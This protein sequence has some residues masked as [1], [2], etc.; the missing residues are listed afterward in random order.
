MH[1][2]CPAPSALCLCE[3]GGQVGHVPTPT[4]LTSA[5][6]TCATPRGSDTCEL[7][8]ENCE[9]PCD[10]VLGSVDGG[11]AVMM[12]GLDYERLVLAAGP[13]GLMQVRS[14]LLKGRGASCHVTQ[15]HV[16]GAAVHQS[17][18]HGCWVSCQFVNQP[19]IGVTLFMTVGAINPGP[20]RTVHGFSINEY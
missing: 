4:P 5:P 15:P 19:V 6:P 11:V 12:S 2:P 1:G 14:G 8:F 16:M 7:V 10:N 9:V 3:W 20:N 18:T 17:W 13:L